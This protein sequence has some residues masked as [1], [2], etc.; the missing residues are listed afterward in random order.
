MTDTERRI[1]IFEDTDEQYEQIQEPLER[2]L[3]DEGI[4]IDRFGG[5]DEE[6][7]EEREGSD[8]AREAIE[9]PRPPSLVVLDW[10]L[11]KLPVAVRREHVKVA[12]E[13]LH[14]PLCVYHRDKQGQFSHA[15]RLKNWDE[16]VI[17]IDPKE[18]AANVAEACANL[19]RGFVEI[20]RSLERAEEGH[21]KSAI[22]DILDAPPGAEAQLDQYSWGRS[23]AVGIARDAESSDRP[24]AAATFIGYWIYNQLLP[25]PGVLLHSRALDSYLGIES[26]VLDENPEIRAEF[27]SARYEGPFSDIR[28]HWWTSD[29]DEIRAEYTES[30]DSSLVEGPQLL[31]RMGFDD[32]GP[33]EC[34]EGHEGG[35]FYCILTDKPVCKDHS[36]RPKGW[37]PI[38]A[39]RARIHEAAYE[40]IQPWMPD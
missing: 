34:V 24:R 25:F 6:D 31:S 35:G 15:E 40:Q 1:L 36:V 2:F 28:R 14:V 32:I 30:D 3:E 10:D 33:A 16:H 21:L 20:H 17:K 11:S 22:Q 39:S 26:G 12:C 13:E 4:A 19:A 38:G 5:F 37:I 9:E 27:D 18:E 7:I 8:L 23:E 29:V